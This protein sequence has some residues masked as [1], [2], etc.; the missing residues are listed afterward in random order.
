MSALGLW[1][2]HAG[3]IYIYICSLAHY[4]LP[5]IRFPLLPSCVIPRSAGDG[6]KH[7]MSGGKPGYFPTFDMVPHPTPLNL[8]DPFGNMKA[9]TEESKARGRLVSGCTL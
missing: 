7:Y 6:E 2:V 3:A 1:D 5:P 8:F 4:P 9:K